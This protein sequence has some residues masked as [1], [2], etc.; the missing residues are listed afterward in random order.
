MDDAA[1]KSS[2]VQRSRYLLPSGWERA[3]RLVHARSTCVERTVYTCSAVLS[4][5]YPEL[6]DSP[7]PTGCGGSGGGDSGSGSGNGSSG[8]SGTAAA[9]VDVHLSASRDVD[10]FLVHNAER[11]PRL[12]SL[13]AQGQRLTTANLDEEQAAVVAQVGV[14]FP[15][16]A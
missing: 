8:A 6:S 10:E 12:R 5:L 9:T 1:A 4:G 2:G 15:Q 14:P 7:T 16:F 3:S 11:C 13:F